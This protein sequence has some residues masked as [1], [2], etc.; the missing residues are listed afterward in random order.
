M[1]STFIKNNHMELIDKLKKGTITYLIETHN[2][3]QT[4]E[5]NNDVYFNNLVKLVNNFECDYK[6]ENDEIDT[7]EISI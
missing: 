3:F 2:A 4:T 6:Y 5:G 1:N 7:I